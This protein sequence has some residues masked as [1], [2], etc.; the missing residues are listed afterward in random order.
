[1]IDKYGHLRC[2]GCGKLLALRLEGDL[3]IVCPRCKRFNHFVKPLELTKKE[4]CD[5]VKITKE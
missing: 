3:E 1:M 2:D 4:N 5:M